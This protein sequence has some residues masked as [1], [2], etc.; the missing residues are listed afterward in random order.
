MA[1]RARD[2]RKMRTIIIAAFR[3]VMTDIFGRLASLADGEVAV[4]SFVAIK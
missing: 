1:P 2:G 4:I 3:R